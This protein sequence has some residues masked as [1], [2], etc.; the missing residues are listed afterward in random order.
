MKLQEVARRHKRENELAKR[1][2]KRAEP[3]LAKLTPGRNF[4]G[5]RDFETLAEWL[6]FENNGVKRRVLFEGQIRLDGM[7][8]EVRK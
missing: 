6:Y 4:L 2:E 3:V 8:V 5:K 7:T 1:R